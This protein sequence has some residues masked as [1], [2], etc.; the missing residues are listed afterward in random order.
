M[1]VS[2][3]AG[4]TEIDLQIY[5]E[6]AVMIMIRLS[7]FRSRVTESTVPSPLHP[8]V[9]CVLSLDLLPESLP[10]SFVCLGGS[11][12]PGNITY[13]R[14]SKPQLVCIHL[15]GRLGRVTFKGPFLFP[16]EQ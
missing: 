1:L 4:Y 16:L 11:R 13:P 15:F 3:T 2:T 10:L 8:S 6:N 12:F 14:L 9:V 7:R 5:S